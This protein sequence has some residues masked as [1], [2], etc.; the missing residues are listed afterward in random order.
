M[1]TVVNVMKKQIH[2]KIK[3]S[4]LWVL[5]AVAALIGVVSTANSFDGNPSKQPNIIFIQT[6]DQ[7][8]ASLD[9]IRPDTGNFA[10]P[11]IR[12][13]A[14]NGVNFSNNFLSHGLC[15][16]SRATFLTGQY[17]HNHGVY[18]NNAPYGGFG[19]L[20][21]SNTLPVWLKEAGYYNI[22]IGKYMN[23]YQEALTQGAPP[24]PPGWDKWFT[25]LDG[26]KFFNY[27]V[28]QE[29]GTTLSFGNNV[30]DYQTDVLARRAARYIANIP[31]RNQPFF[32]VVNFVAPHVGFGAGP[33]SG[34]HPV[35]APRHIG[36][37]DSYA[38]IFSPSFNEADV[39]DKPHNVAS[40]SLITQNAVAAIEESMR[41]RLEALLAVDEGVGL[42]LEALTRK[43]LLE[44]TII[45]FVSD[46]GVQQGEH[47]IISG[48]NRPY[49]ESIHVPLY[50]QGPGIPKGKV[51]SNVVSNI[52]YAP[53]IMDLADAAPGLIMD[54]ESLLPLMNNSLIPWREGIFLE[55]YRM[56]NF[57]GYLRGVRTNDKAYIEYEYGTVPD[58]IG[59]DEIELYSTKPDSCRLVGDPYQLESQH[60]NPCYA[61]LIEK[62]QALVE[63]KKNCS[64]L[65]CSW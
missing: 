30:G 36:V 27:S 17:E 31:S 28:M 5:V 14:A 32:M 34:P 3:S 53:T 55:N 22:H 18:T 4:T 38:P 58:T 52:D 20:D 65:S 44:N 2:Q 60:A 46:N 50:I 61:K 54:G 24:V 29:D 64:G 42:I 56:D 63:E 13:L 11:N 48:K 45:M 25:F 19:R 9:A 59:P 6:D 16:P 51:I 40:L 62:F 12:S 26:S 35:P 39:T 7:D 15:C 21:H 33:G 8:L 23:G 1:P 37:F 57:G 10:Y 43:E 41:L 47:R 49:D